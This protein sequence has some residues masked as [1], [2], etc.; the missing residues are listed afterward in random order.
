[1][2][3]NVVLGAFALLL[4]TLSAVSVL[5]HEPP[6]AATLARCP[7]GIDGRWV[8]HNGLYCTIDHSGVL[9]Y[10]NA[11]HADQELD[12]LREDVDQLRKEVARLQ[13]H[14]RKAP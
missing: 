13:R 8:K 3:N 11:R 14:H 10:S 1:M 12:A 5:A 7:G 4:I 2:R 6:S 9:H